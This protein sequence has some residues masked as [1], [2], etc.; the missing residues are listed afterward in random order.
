MTP[1]T[2]PLPLCVPVRAKRRHGWQQHA[3]HLALR[4]WLDE[5]KAGYD[6]RNGTASRKTAADARWTAM[7]A[8]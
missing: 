4:A 2:L 3:G 1:D 6:A 8:I 7:R 5:R